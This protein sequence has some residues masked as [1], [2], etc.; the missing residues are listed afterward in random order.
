MMVLEMLLRARQRLVGKAM[1][2]EALSSFDREVGP[3]VVE[4]YISRLRRR[5]GELRAGIM[6][7][8]ERGLGYRAVSQA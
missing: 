2:E 1:L 5:L 3:N 6:I 4:V 8:T 7:Q